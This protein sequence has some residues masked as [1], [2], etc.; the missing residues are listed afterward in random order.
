MDCEG[1]FR[2][3]PDNSFHLRSSALHL[4]KEF[5]VIN[6]MGDCNEIMDCRLNGNR[7]TLKSPQLDQRYLPMQ[8]ESVDGF[9][10]MRTDPP[11]LLG[12]GHTIQRGLLQ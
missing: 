8:R 1:C 4:Y 6:N 10:A 12:T 9:P 3:S 11:L 7:Q 2:F 5:A